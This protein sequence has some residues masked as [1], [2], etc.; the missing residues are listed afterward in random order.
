MERKR[1]RIFDRIKHY[2]MIFFGT[3]LLSF[4]TAVFILPY[5]LIVGGVS[6]YSILLHRMIPI[7]WLTVDLW[8]GIL[9][10]GLFLLGMVFLGRGFALKTLMSTV[11]YPFGVS[12]FLPLGDPEVLGGFFCMTNHPHPEL[13]LLLSAVVGGILVG[14]G[15]ALAFL[16]GGS[17]GGVDILALVLCKYFKKLRSSVVMFC[18]DGLAILLGV[19]LIQDLVFTLL[20]ILSVLISAVMIDK[21]FLGGDRAYVAQ[22][23]TDRPQSVSQSLIDSL[24]RSTSIWEVQGGYTKRMHAVVMVSFTM[25]QYAEVMQVVRRE[26]P[27]AFV[28]IHRAHEIRGE[29]WTE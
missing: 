23:V 14:V 21:V 4:A 22:I 3:L 10:W 28:T 20:G 25:R 19:F 5:D 17:T 12:A 6:S 16:G 8:I 15:C 27:G 24:E 18:L 7:H 26:D 29:G 9:T 2:A 1:S 11:V 13:A